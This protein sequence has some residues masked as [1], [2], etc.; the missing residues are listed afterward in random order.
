MKLDNQVTN[1]E[2]SKKL[3]ELGAK[4]KSL[5][6]WNIFTDPNTNKKRKILAYNLSKTFGDYYSAFT[7]AELGEMLPLRILNNVGQQ[8]DGKYYCQLG[9]KFIS[10]DTEANAR[11]KM[12][13]Y[14]IENKLISG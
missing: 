7:V 13:I 9:I 5:F 10:S 2:L 3:K 12:K 1:L 6:W 14:L 11:A 4:Q 8:T